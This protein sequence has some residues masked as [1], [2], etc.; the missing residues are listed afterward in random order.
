MISSG[1]SFL[2][3]VWNASW[4]SYSTL[5][6]ERPVQVSCSR[7]KYSDS[8]FLPMCLRENG[9]QISFYRTLL[10]G[11]INAFVCKI[12]WLQ[13]GGSIGAGDQVGGTFYQKPLQVIS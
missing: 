10:T 1:R 2:F 13:T 4:W 5:R 6:Q 3:V 11:A 9:E 8:Q 12:E 7:I